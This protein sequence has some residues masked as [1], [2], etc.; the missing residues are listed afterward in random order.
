M[1]RVCHRPPTRIRIRWD[2][3]APV[4][5]RAVSVAAASCARAGRHGSA[6]PGRSGGRIAIT[7]VPGSSSALH[8]ATT[9]G[10]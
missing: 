3:G 4:A 7:L 6:G 2:A 9:I 1:T 10:A 5:V 8:R